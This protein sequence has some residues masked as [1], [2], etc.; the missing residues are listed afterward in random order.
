[1]KAPEA[2][3]LQTQQVPDSHLPDKSGWRARQLINQTPPSC[4]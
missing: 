2:R 4:T 3:E 1:M